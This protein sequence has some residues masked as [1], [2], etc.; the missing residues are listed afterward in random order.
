MESSLPE[1]I[2]S[3]QNRSFWLIFALMFNVGTPEIVKDEIFEL[4]LDPTIDV[5]SI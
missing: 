5:A 2:G 4:K 1:L 3:D